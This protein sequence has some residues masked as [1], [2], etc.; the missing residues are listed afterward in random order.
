MAK[1]ELQPKLLTVKQF[2]QYMSVGETTARQ[3]LSATNCPY[4]IRIGGKLMANK[5]ELDKWISSR[6]GQ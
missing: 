5:T 2:C 1:S 4:R 6:T 3:M